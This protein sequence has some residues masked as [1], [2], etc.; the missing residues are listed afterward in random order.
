M[1]DP[2]GH[3]RQRGQFGREREHVLGERAN[4]REVAVAAMLGERVAQGLEV[5]RGVVHTEA[6]VPEVVLEIAERAVKLGEHTARFVRL[7]R[8]LERV[9]RDAIDS[10]ER[11]PDSA[12]VLEP[13]LAVAAS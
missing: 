9:A 4:G 11:A 1:H 12:V 3:R 8:R 2:V 5:T 7:R 6:A 13:E 10:C